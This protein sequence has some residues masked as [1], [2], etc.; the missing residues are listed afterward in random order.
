MRNWG[1]QAKVLFLAL[2]PL[3]AIV[4]LTSLHFI[5]KRIQEH[6]RLLGERGAAIARHLAPACEYG[7]LSGNRAML[8]HLA[9]SALREA[10]VRTVTITD[11]QGQI[12]A[13]AARTDTGQGRSHVFNTPIYQSQ[14]IF[15]ELDEVAVLARAT[16]AESARAIGSVTVELSDAGTRAQ[17]SRI[18]VETLLITLIGLVLT[19]VFALRMAGGVTRP[20]LALTAAVQRIKE[21]DLSQRVTT[22]TGGEIGELEAGVNAM[23]EALEAARERE[24]KQAEDALYLEKV[25]AQVTLES[26]GDGVIATDA[27]GNIVYMNSVAEQ[28]TGWR[29][30]NA[31]GKRLC[32][33]F[34]IFDETASVVE[35]YPIHYCL[36]E[37]RTIRH[38]SHHLLLGRGGERVEIQDSAAPIRDRDGSIIGAVV[39]FH[40]ITEI[41]DMVRRMAFLASHDPL[42][43]LLNRREFETRLEQLLA[44]ARSEGS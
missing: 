43:G 3:M 16:P 14:V 22:R 29:K 34:R 37:G 6:G 15:D 12:L 4:L 13:R 11:L 42:T 30:E 2:V 24:K 1:I 31:E 26:I 33:V 20:I 40:D 44:S 10:D 25:R 36:E 35:E 21:G 18:A 38:D 8:Q 41:Q 9:Q 28:F 7:V 19:A 17:Q 5:A 32:E 39:V 27:A 23:A